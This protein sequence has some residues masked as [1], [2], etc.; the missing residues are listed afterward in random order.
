MTS[1]TDTARAAHDAGFPDGELV[2]AV[3]V[4]IAESGLNERA[5]HR[6]SNG[7]VDYGLWQI[8]S[9][10]NFPEI[11]AG[12][13]SDPKVNAQLA[14][15][16]WHAQG[17]DAWSTHKPTDPLGYGRYAGARPVAAAAVAAAGFTSAAASGV[18]GTPAD[19]ADSATGTAGDVL[20]GAA[21]IARA[22]LAALAWLE[23]PD[24]WTRILKV[25]L[26]GGLV[27][28]GAYLFVQ[29]TA[30]KTAAPVAAQVLGVGGRVG[31]VRTVATKVGESA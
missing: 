16:V 31:A 18:V 20:S 27:L 22:P 30:L 24:T 29:S 13:W 26:G 11:T 28:A 7:S 9:V 12:Q 1:A 17:W 3:A 23:R 10:H 25:F 15:R 5:T 14:L 8:N 6:N 21:A 19:V 4:A 2:T